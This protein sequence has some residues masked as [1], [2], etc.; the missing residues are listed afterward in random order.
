[1]K[2]KRM[3]VNEK[4]WSF[5]GDDRLILIQNDRSFFMPWMMTI[6]QAENDDQDEGNVFLARTFP[7]TN[8]SCVCEKF[9]CRFEIALQNETTQENVGDAVERNVREKVVYRAIDP[10]KESVR[11]VLDFLPGFL[12]PAFHRII[13]FFDAFSE[14]SFTQTVLNYWQVK[15][16]F[17]EDKY[18]KVFRA[19]ESF[20][21]ENAEI[22]VGKHTFSF[23]ANEFCARGEYDFSI[24]EGAF[25]LP[26]EQ[27]VLRWQDFLTS[28]RLT[29]RIRKAYGETFFPPLFIEGLFC[30]RP[31]EEIKEAVD[32]LRRSDRQVFFVERGENELLRSLCDK[33]IDL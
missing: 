16:V 20:V 30:D 33:T 15:T 26:H 22:K 32:L 3:Q 25:P 9:G 13:C 18:E 5:D 23:Y 14:K 2:I 27:W 11:S 19:I 29:E 7:N 17:H 4:V 12:M 28:V 10:P 8:L 1:M 24:E 6:F 21:R 31:Q